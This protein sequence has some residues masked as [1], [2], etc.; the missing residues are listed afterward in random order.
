MLPTAPVRESKAEADAAAVAAAAAA[1]GPTPA[2][3]AAAVELLTPVDTTATAGSAA[4]GTDAAAAG[5]VLASGT[6]AAVE[7]AAAG[8]DASAAGASAGSAAGARGGSTAVARA[9]DK[10]DPG[11]FGP[12]CIVDTTLSARTCV[13][14]SAKGCGACVSAAHDCRWCPSTR[15]CIPGALVGSAAAAATYRAMRRPHR[16]GMEFGMG[17]DRHLFSVFAE[18]ATQIEARDATNASGGHA[19][20]GTPAAAAE[21]EAA[22][23]KAAAATN[24]AAAAAK[25]AAAGVPET[26]PDADTIANFGRHKGKANKLKTPTGANGKPA[27]PGAGAGAGAGA[28]S[29]AVAGAAGGDSGEGKGAGRSDTAGVGAGAG[30]GAGAGGIAAAGAGAGS[31]NSDHGGAAGGKNGSGS[32]SGKSGGGAGGM[33]SSGVASLISTVKST[34]TGSVSGSGSGGAGGGGGSGG[35]G[36]EGTTSATETDEDDPWFSICPD[37]DSIVVHAEECPLDGDAYLVWDFFFGLL[38]IGFFTTY[39]VKHY[40]TKHAH[41]LPGW[42]IFLTSCVHN[43]CVGALCSICIAVCINNV[44]VEVTLSRQFSYVF[45][46]LYLIIGVF[47]AWSRG[48][49]RRMQLAA[50]ASRAAGS[51]DHIPFFRDLDAAS[52][53]DDDDDDYAGYAASTAAAGREEAGLL[54]HGHGGG[55]KASRGHKARIGLSSLYDPAAPPSAL[56][57]LDAVPAAGAMTGALEGVPRGSAVPMQVVRS[58]GGGARSLVP[59]APVPAITARELRRT[60]CCTLTAI[61]TLFSV[62]LTLASALCMS[63]HHVPLLTLAT[64]LR[65]PTFFLLAGSLSFC[66]VFVALEIGYVSQRLIYKIRTAALEQDADAA[67]RSRWY[68]APTAPSAFASASSRRLATSRSRAAAAAGSPLALSRVLKAGAGT[69][70]PFSHSLDEMRFMCFAALMG[71]LYFGYTFGVVDGGNRTRGHMDLALQQS[72]YYRFPI[73]SVTGMITAVLTE[74]FRYRRDL[75]EQTRRAPAKVAVGTAPAA[76]AGSAGAGSS[77]GAADAAGAA[78]KAAAA[79]AGKG[80]SQQQLQQQH[81]RKQHQRFNGGGGGGGG[82]ATDTDLDDDPYALYAAGGGGGGAVHKGGFAQFDDHL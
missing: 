55:G 81:A 46:L 75:A 35:G 16:M 53:S 64:A 73:A 69:E 77:A 79:G 50:A 44:L 67:A 56:A 30:K 68:S 65:I 25:A 54:G 29:A 24:A 42:V 6:D 61:L 39:V 10:C 74:V 58:P 1:E 57:A 38:I 3:V 28:D 78:G 37:V 36:G 21:G 32:G 40:A 17:L 19:G 12:S 45:A 59:A 70:M 62:A 20:S 2:S 8:A 51:R 22:A 34:V 48:V 52:G 49:V 63:L 14:A 26:E 47:V 7:A 27:K 41:E 43:A 4:A 76:A 72:N 15:R 82:G 80:L 5:V 23:A 31:G 13:L 60:G 66:I 71:G 9:Q 11:F 18:M 33:V